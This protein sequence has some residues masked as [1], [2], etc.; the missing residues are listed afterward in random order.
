MVNDDKNYLDL[1]EMMNFYNEN[2]NVSSEY[3]TDYGCQCR[4]NLDRYHNGLGRAKDSLDKGCSQW[5]QCL[6]K[7][8]K[9][10][11]KVSYFRNIDRTKTVR[12]R[13]LRRR[14]HKSK[15]EVQSC[16]RKWPVPMCAVDFNL[17]TGN[18]R[19]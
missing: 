7:R 6:K 4:G 17:S 5:R 3:L 14:V 1:V 19:V 10:F 15:L 9:Y 13:H 18:V 16:V 8:S 12:E 11:Y 2:W